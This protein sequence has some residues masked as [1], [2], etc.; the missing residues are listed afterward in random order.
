MT[1]K[2]KLYNFCFSQFICCLY[3]VIVIKEYTPDTDR[4]WETLYFISVAWTIIPQ[5]KTISL[6]TKH[7]TMC[8]HDDVSVDRSQL[9]YGS[10]GPSSARWDLQRGRV[11]AREEEGDVSWPLHKPLALSNSRST[12]CRNPETIEAKS[13]KRT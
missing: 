1:K 4:S 9:A 13:L 10:P 5:D 8:C 11:Q 2:V 12:L 7:L 3:D 6:A